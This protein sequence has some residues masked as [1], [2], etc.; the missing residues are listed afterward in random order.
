[1]TG[2]DIRT[3]LASGD[4]DKIK[5]LAKNALALACRV[6]PLEASRC[7]PQGSMPVNPNMIDYEV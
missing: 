7:R 6:Q 1:M 4:P 3:S 5:K 2:M